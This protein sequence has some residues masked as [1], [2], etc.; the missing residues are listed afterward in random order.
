M[1]ANK[2]VLKGSGVE[3]DFTIGAN[4]SFPA[5]TYKAGAFQKSF[6]PAQIGTENAGLRRLPWRCPII[7]A[8]LR[9]SPSSS[10][11][12]LSRGPYAA[13]RSNRSQGQARG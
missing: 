4:P 3:V 11:P 5:L 2:F 7:V 13:Q 12:G 6:L 10:S 1:P 8:S 9:P